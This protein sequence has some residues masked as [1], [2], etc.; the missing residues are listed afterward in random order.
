MYH[1]SDDKR[2]KQ[3]AE[4]IY[5][6]LCDCLT[7]KSFDQITVT[8][9]QR[10]S[11]VARTTFYR[12]FDN[13]AD[14]LYWKCDACFQEVLGSYTPERF[15]NEMELALHYF[16]Y[17][18]DHSDILELLVKI[19]RQD[20]IYVCH[21]KNAQLLQ[22]RYGPVPGLSESHSRYFMA[23]RTGFTISILTAWLSGG[24]KETPEEIVAILR[25][26]MILLVHSN[27]AALTDTNAAEKS[28]TAPR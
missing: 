12:A 19:N 1:I 5:S 2:A 13:P 6:G 21:M 28:R 4:L 24:R 18:M 27:L 26:Q 15:P 16:R 23:I 14:V 20:I 11:G 7:R 10:A 17:W 22:Q 25:E 9:L 8:D 3:S